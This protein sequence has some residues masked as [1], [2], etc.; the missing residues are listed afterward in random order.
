MAG[1]TW[2]ATSAETHTAQQWGAARRPL[3]GG[4]AVQGPPGRGPG[5]R[6]TWSWANSPWRHGASPSV[7]PRHTA[8]PRRAP[9]SGAMGG[10]GSRRLARGHV[11]DRQPAHRAA[12]GTARTRSSSCCVRSGSRAPRGDVIALA[13]ARPRTSAARTGRS[14]TC[15]ATGASC[16][17][18][19]P[20]AGAWRVGPRAP[21]KI[22]SPLIEPRQASRRSRSPRGFQVDA[23]L[24]ARRN[25]RPADRAAPRAHAL[26]PP[27]WSR[28]RRV[29]A[30]CRLAAGR[31]HR[32]GQRV[33]TDVRCVVPFV[34]R[35]W[36][37]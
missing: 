17:P 28:V 32:S 14:P 19:A 13:T 10:T 15:C 1:T 22:G 35:V 5:P 20:R 24:P 6:T 25:G 11:E 16:P 33:R 3:N 18:Q 8:S 34:V 7:R 2:P 30:G 23:G 36:R 21:S 12:S 29:E 4:S 26:G 27:A 37:A 9:T 31:D